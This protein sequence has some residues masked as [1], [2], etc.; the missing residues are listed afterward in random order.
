MRKTS[1]FGGQEGPGS[2]TDEDRLQDDR[3]GRHVATM[4]FRDQILREQ[5][6]L[7][8]RQVL[9]MANNEPVVPLQDVVDTAS[10]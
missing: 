9:Y 3:E 1:L 8:Q 5:P 10:C 4:T 7:R 2:G 6:G